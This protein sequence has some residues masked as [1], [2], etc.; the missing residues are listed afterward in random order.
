MIIEIL[1]FDLE[2]ACQPGRPPLEI[3]MAHSK[4]LIKLMA[5]KVR[6]NNN[7]FYKNLTF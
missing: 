1:I 6:I 5:N 4:Q 2:S 3:A 7:T